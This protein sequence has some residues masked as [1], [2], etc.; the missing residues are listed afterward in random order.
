MKEKLTK[1]DSI[2]SGEM[3]A[4]VIN[5]AFFAMI[6]RNGLY[7]DYFHYWAKRNTPA[8]GMN[9]SQAW[10]NW[11]KISTPAQYIAGA[12]NWAESSVPRCAWVDIDTKWR[13]WL[14]ENLK[15]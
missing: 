1:N 7:L 15:K 2:S 13:V 5:A 9:I 4:E 3:S 6:S 14:S 12:F 11:A 10:E 8:Y